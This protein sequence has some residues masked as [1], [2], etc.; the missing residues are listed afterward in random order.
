MNYLHETQTNLEK[1]FLTR[2]LQV[3]KHLNIPNNSQKELLEIFKQKY[4]QNFVDLTDDITFTSNQFLD[5]WQNFFSC[6]DLSRTN[7]LTQ[8]FINSFYKHWKLS[9]QELQNRLNHHADLDLYI[10]LYDD[11]Y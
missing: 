11:Y 9:L 10:E 3:M 5:D 7:E 4:L 1:Q 2:L 8:T 6:P